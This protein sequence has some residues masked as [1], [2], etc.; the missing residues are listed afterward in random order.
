MTL[1]ITKLADSIKKKNADAS[2]AYI[3]FN[4][5]EVSEPDKYEQVRI[6]VLGIILK[7]GMSL[8]RL[9]QDELMKLFESKL[10]VKVTQKQLTEDKREFNIESGY[11]VIKINIAKK[12]TFKPK[13]GDAVNYYEWIFQEFVKQDIIDKC[14]SERETS[15][16]NDFD[17]IEIL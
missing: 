5:S 6:P 9:A 15:K 12:K 7:K 14:L 16:D 11:Q 3:L 8:K 4:T 17:M 1:T 13:Q 2:V 10:E